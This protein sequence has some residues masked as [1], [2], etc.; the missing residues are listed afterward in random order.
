MRW[1]VLVLALV[2]TPVGAS[3]FK[4]GSIGCER[5]IALHDNRN[6]LHELDGRDLLNT[7]HAI[8][9]I[10]G[11]LRAA[12]ERPTAE[13][14]RFFAALRAACTEK[15]GSLDRTVRIAAALLRAM[16]EVSPLPD[17]RP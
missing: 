9:Y 12:A 4:A 13:R 5:A 15:G 7:V 17:A 6:K 3:P 11:A 1:A 16:R 8:A 14:D 10:E 2:V